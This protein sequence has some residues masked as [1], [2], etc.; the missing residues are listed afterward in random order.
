M[1][2][3]PAEPGIHPPR[4]ILIIDDGVSAA[5]ML[6]LFFQLEGFEVRTAYNGEDGVQAAAEML[7]DVILLDLAMPVMSGFD[8]A[9]SI[10][11]N[12]ALKDS[13]LVALTGW[14]DDDDRLKTKAA[15]FDKHIEKPVD[16]GILR[17]MLADFTSR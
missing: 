17:Q 15:G 12:P 6:A 8:A 10:R 2:P 1:S 16:P 3:A 4:K 5:E 13:F 9:R 14:G 7:P 11:S